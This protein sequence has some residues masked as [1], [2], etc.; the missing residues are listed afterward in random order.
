MVA[1]VRLPEDL[2]KEVAELCNE[3]GDLF[4]QFGKE[5]EGV[6]GFEVVEVRIAEFVEDLAVECGEQDLLVAVAAV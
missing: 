1:E 2:F 3:L 5:V 6:D 4:F